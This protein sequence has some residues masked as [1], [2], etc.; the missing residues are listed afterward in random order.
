MYTVELYRGKLSIIM[1][2]GAKPSNQDNRKCMFENKL[3]ELELEETLYIDLVELPEPKE[4]C[5]KT[6]RETIMENI[7]EFSDNEE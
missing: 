3:C 4:T 6:A 5:Y 7:M 2:A 1:S